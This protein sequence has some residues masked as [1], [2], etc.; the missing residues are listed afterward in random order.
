MKLLK[1]ILLLGVLLV[2]H[3][4]TAQGT[5]P[6][7]KI[8]K[9]HVK[10]KCSMC[11][12]RIQTFAILT[13]GV[14]KAEYDLERQILSM[15]VNKNTFDKDQLHQN[16]A[17][18]GHGTNKF[19]A[20]EEA[21]A[22]LPACCQYVGAPIVDKENT[23]DGNIIEFTDVESTKP[24]G[25]PNSI[26]GM[27]YERDPVGNRMPLIGATVR[28]LG[29]T[30]GTVTDL[31]GQFYLDR[32]PEVE[33]IV[34]SYVGYQTDT[35]SMENQ[36]LVSIVLTDATTLSTVEVVHR[37]RTTEIS[38]LNPIK[39]QEI[40]E[41]EFLKAACC[42]IAESFETNPSVDV[43]FTDAV[44]GTRKI[45]LLGLEGPNIQ[46]MR[47]NMPYIRGLASIYGFEFTPATWLE[48]MQLNMGTG[49]VAN[50][51][52]GLAGQINVELKKPCSNMEKLYL[53]LYANEGGRTELNANI[54]H[55]IN[56]KWYAAT[57]LHTKKNFR[58]NDRNDDGFLDSPL[59]EH[60]IAL[61]RWKFIGDNGFRW[62]AG[63]KGTYFDNVS[64]QV[65][66]D[67]ESD[68]QTSDIWGA[69]TKIRRVE[70]WMKFGKVFLDNPLASMG[71]Q[72]S[73]SHHDQDAIFGARV[74]DAKQSAFYANFLY[75]NVIKSS[76]HKYRLG[77]SFQYDKFDELVLVSPFD[78]EEISTGI[79][80]EYSFQP[81]EKFTAVFGIRQ[82][83][84]NS[85]GLF[86]TP[87]TNLRYAPNDDTVFRL[88]AGR[89]LRTANVFAENIGMFASNRRILLSPEAPANY[90]N[91]LLPEIGW[92]FG[93]NV[94]KAVRIG[95]KEVIFG[96]DY[97]YTF[98]ESQVI[99][100][101]DRNPQEVRIYNLGGQSYSHSIQAQIDAEILPMLD[102][103]VAYRYNDVKTDYLDGLLR[104]PLIS[105]HR[106][107]I[108]MAYEIENKWAFDA[109]FNWQGARRIPN[110]SSNPEEFRL[111][112][113]SP[114]FVTL[115]G[116]ITRKWKMFD[117][118]IGV[119]NA[120]NYRQDNPIISAENPNSD[121]FD[122][123][124][125]W[126]PIFGRNIYTGFR[127]KIK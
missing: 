36:S 102:V 71:L 119:E 34:V 63:V 84:H 61:H 89:S 54:R 115:N 65:G 64:G 11:S 29:Q 103:R 35:I 120:L 126:G 107:F 116:Q 112:S 53:N 16:M 117:W 45:Q 8:V 18:A 13:P 113:F 3:I 105:A 50:G 30:D 38:Y 55:D 49:S 22:N 37:K 114:D 25:E 79:F 33:D 67:Q 31:E 44:T 66:Y 91:G 106:A 43:S 5:P 95:A 69:S 10:G 124:L 104:K 51:F 52:E 19:K 96:A 86:F 56:D 123:S 26:N 75:Q 7:S 57:L 32:V 39:V 41:K 1:F 99:V 111:S 14:M 97:Y 27:I 60:F 9:I 47:E 2:A 98:F 17:N 92:N 109:T 125:V 21:Y 70:G 4:A 80:G 101:Y 23:V 28:W 122:S 77:Y 15:T 93:A 46:V 72:I 20:D 78:R 6:V 24:N 74:Y 12:D 110:T 42:N 85:Y 81:S 94:S 59:A 127:Y 76:K 40:D 88:A 118:Y 68:P 82:D 58:E 90:P 73:G 87:R 83:H 100:D 121:F 62:Q 48:G 108:N